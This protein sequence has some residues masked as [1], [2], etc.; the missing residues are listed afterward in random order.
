[1][2]DEVDAAGTDRPEDPDQWGNWGDKALYENWEAA[3]AEARDALMRL[4]VDPNDDGPD[5]D[6]PDTLASNMLDHLDKAVRIALFDKH[7]PDFPDA[8]GIEIEVTVKPQ[9]KPCRRHAVKT[10][11]QVAANQTDPKYRHDKLTIHMTC[12]K[13]GWIGT[14]AWRYTGKK[15][16]TGYTATYVVPDAPQAIDGQILFVFNGLES[17]PDP[18]QA[19]PPGILQPVLQWTTEAD[20]WSGWAVRSWYVPATYAPTFDMMPPL[21]K[22]MPFSNAAKPAWTKAV[23]VDAGKTVRGSISWDEASKQYVSKF[24]IDGQDTASLAVRRILPLTY[25]V[26]VIEAYRIKNKKNN[27][28]DVTMTDIALSVEGIGAVE[29]VW[30][31]GTDDSGSHIHHG[32]NRLQAYTIVADYPNRSLTFTRKKA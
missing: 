18:A 16:F 15:K 20:G 25:P 1:M 30:D 24:V 26:A 19:K 14:A 28:V 5:P 27:L 7:Q 3:I 13:G 23:K 6:D 21:D 4:P 17:L 10:I 11:W 2:N 32:T 22:E 31:V 8:S 12:P 9:V 29:P